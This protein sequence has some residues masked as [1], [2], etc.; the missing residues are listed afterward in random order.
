MSEE[1]PFDE[2]DVSCCVC[3]ERVAKLSEHF[4]GDVVTVDFL[5]DLLSA[6]PG[7]MEVT[8]WRSILIS[9]SFKRKGG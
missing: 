9:D 2:C 4:D 6:F 1:K 5:K 7:D 3:K 8:G